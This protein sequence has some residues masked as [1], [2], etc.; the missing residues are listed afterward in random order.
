MEYRRSQHSSEVTETYHYR[1]WADFV[2]CASIEKWNSIQPVNSDLFKREKCTTGDR[3][4]LCKCV[5]CLF[6]VILVPYI[7]RVFTQRTLCLKLKDEDVTSWSVSAEKGGNEIKV[8][9]GQRKK[10][11]GE[12][13]RHERN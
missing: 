10:E 6:V 2:T 12:G 3:L 9:E 13:W 4:W 5:I 7:L 1:Q 11:K 8:Q